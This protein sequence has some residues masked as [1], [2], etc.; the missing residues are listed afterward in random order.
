MDRVVK[1]PK[2]WLYIIED[3]VHSVVRKVKCRDGHQGQLTE[4]IEGGFSL[5]CEPPSD[6]AANAHLFDSFLI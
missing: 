1:A 6:V 3:A 2:I 5:V 4:V